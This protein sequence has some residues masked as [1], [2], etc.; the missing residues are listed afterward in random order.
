MLHYYSRTHYELLQPYYR[1]WGII[2]ELHQ[3]LIC[4][5]IIQVTPLIAHHIC[6]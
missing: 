6:V 3:I 5:E 1:E 2:P 4:I